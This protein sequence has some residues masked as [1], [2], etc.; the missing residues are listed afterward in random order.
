MTVDGDTALVESR[1]RLDATIY[2]ARRVWPIASTAQ[3]R[4][5]DGRWVI[6]RS[7]STTF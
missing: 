2:G 7:A 3:L 1:S 5:I 4:R 6:A